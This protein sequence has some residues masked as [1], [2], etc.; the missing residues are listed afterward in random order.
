MIELIA[1]GKGLASRMAHE[2]VFPSGLSADM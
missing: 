1:C 2:F